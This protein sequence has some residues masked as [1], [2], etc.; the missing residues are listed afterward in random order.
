MLPL[1][2]NN[3]GRSAVFFDRDGVL[4]KVSIRDGLPV[5]PLTLEEFVVVPGIGDQI[6]ILRAAGILTIVATNQ[7]AVGRG[8]LKTE[9][10]ER[11]HALLTTTAD[12][13]ALMVCP[14][15]E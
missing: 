2:S 4:T 11:M 15:V 5:G 12:F 9:T 14:H 3:I 8:L 10:M 1:P 13:D 7:P 6:G